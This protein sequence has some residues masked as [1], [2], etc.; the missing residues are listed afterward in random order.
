MEDGSH[1]VERRPRRW[2]RWLVGLVLLVAVLVPVTVAVVRELQ[3]SP[4]PVPFSTADAKGTTLRVEY[5]GSDCADDVSLDVE[6]SAD[7]VVA[8]VRQTVRAGAC[9]DMGVLRTVEAELEEPLG[10]RTVVDGACRT[11][12]W[13]GR[14]ACV[15]ADR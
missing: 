7:E 6:E 2:R 12:E 13:R 10:R 11:S 4:E 9:N 8:T 1:R 14:P 5:V 3:G 15:T